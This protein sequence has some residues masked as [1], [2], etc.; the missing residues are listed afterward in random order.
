MDLRLWIGNPYELHY[1]WAALKADLHKLFDPVVKASSGYRA[2]VPENRKT[3]P[4]IMPN[5]LLV[6]IVPTYMYGFI[7][8][9]FGPDGSDADRDTG[10]FTRP[11]EG[12]TCSEVYVGDPHEGSSPVTLQVDRMDAS[13]KNLPLDVIRPPAFMARLI[14]HEM[15]H[16]QT[17]YYDKLHNHDGLR[18]AEIKES[19]PLTDTNIKLM[20][21]AIDD[22]IIRHQWNGAWDLPKF[23]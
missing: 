16:N 21:A 7:G 10:G 6:Y 18:R 1:N 13:H 2:F 12:K 20:K 4:A 15:L 22:K 11:Y 17:A 23:R 5:D 3:K 14:F 9:G 8:R 19:T